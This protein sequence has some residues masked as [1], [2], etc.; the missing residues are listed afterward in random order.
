MSRNAGNQPCQYGVDFQH[1]QMSVSITGGNVVSVA[2][3]HCIYTIEHALSCPGT[4]CSG[5]VGRIRYQWCPIT[6]QTT[7]QT[8]G[9]V[10]TI[11]DACQQSFITVSSNG[12]ILCQ[13]RG[14]VLQPLLMEMET[15]YETLGTKSILIHC[16][17]SL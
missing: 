7:V 13:V 2:S 12:S 10:I 9:A 15:V 11:H 1:F 6:A 16:M 3:T 17:Y 5:N 4:Y 8:V 14:Q